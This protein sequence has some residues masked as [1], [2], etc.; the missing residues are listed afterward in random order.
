MAVGTPGAWRVGLALAALLFPA[1]GAIASTPQD[2]READAQLER[3]RWRLAEQAYRDVL[4]D[5]PKS[6]RARIGLGRALAA[7]HQCE[8]ALDLLDSARD[9]FAW[10]VTASMAEG[11]CLE[12]LGELSEAV[13][14]YAHATERAPQYVQPWLG[15]ARA[16]AAQAD[17]AGM[18]EALDGLVLLEG[19]EDLALVVQ[20]EWALRQGDP[21][22]DAWLD[23]AERRLGPNPVTALIEAR[24]W[25]DRGDPA[26]ADEVLLDQ[27]QRTPNHAQLL[28]WRA[29]TLRRLGRVDEAVSLHAET[30]LQALRGA[31][32]SLAFRARLLIDEG[33][34]DVAEHGEMARIDD[35]MAPEALATRWYLAR[36]R[37]DTGLASELA[38]R[39]R[40]CEP[41]TSRHLEQL[42]PWAPSDRASKE[43]DP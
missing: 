4:L 11:Q 36:A 33:L 34:L 27:L 9:T 40:A 23:L 28:L 43:P 10:R 29:E 22:L 38:E 17:E 37:G 32:L 18:E 15:L 19:G 7:T 31:P 30:H 21:A 39:W 3:G 24:A 14:V 12:Q 6:P 8:E 2:L 41:S 20:A 42:V 35:P 25:L 16:L 1:V 26:A 13:E 5:R